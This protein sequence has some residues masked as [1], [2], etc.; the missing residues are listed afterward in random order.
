MQRRRRSQTSA[1]GRLLIGLV[2]A[3]FALISYFASSQYNPVTGE[4][5]YIS[6]TPGQEI[7]L[8]L[9]SAPQM[10][11]QFG[12]LYPDEEIQALVDEVGFR[13][14]RESAVTSQSPL[15]I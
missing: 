10:I 1:A 14:V 6:M 11:Q 15:A 9:Q 12:G 5:Q 7:A 3:V 2:M 4:T 13:L 8:G